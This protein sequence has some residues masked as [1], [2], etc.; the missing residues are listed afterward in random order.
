MR[1]LKMATA[2]VAI[3]GSLFVSG[4]AAAPAEAVV[5]QVGLVNV[6]L[7]DV[8]I[9]NDVNVGVAAEVAAQLCNVKVGPVAVL[10][11]AVDT[12]GTTETVCQTA[13]GPVTLVQS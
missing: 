11:Q 8:N 7:N 2:S 3:A 10:A 6:G 5:N 12:T 13:Q 9:L 4:L 1:A